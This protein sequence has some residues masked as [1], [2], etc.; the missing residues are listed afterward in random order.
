MSDSWPASPPPGDDA[1][2]SLAGQAFEVERA[3]KAL[4]AVDA[5]R[6]EAA[7]LRAELQ[8]VRASGTLT[9]RGPR[10]RPG[11]RSRS[12]V[13]AGAWRLAA[14]CAVI[15]GAAVVAWAAHLGRVGIL[16]TLGGTWLV[17]A[18]FEAVA[19]RSSQPRW[20]PPPPP[21]AVS[22]PVRAVVAP[23]APP[24]VLPESPEPAAEEVGWPSRL[25]P[26][27]A[28]PS[29]AESVEVV[30]EAAL[31]PEPEPEPVPEP[32][33]E[34]DLEP[35]PEPDFEPELEAEPLVLVPEIEPDGGPSA[36]AYAVLEEAA[37][38]RGAD[39]TRPRRWW[40]RFR[41]REQTKLLEAA[42]LEPLVAESEPTLEPEAEQVLIEPEVV[43]DAQPGRRW[44]IFGSREEPAAGDLPAPASIDEEPIAH[45][46][47][48]P[49]LNL[50]LPA[51]ALLEPEDAVEAEAVGTLT[52]LEDVAEPPDAEHAQTDRRWRFFGS[53]E[54]PADLQELES[55]VEEPEPDEPESIAHVENEAEPGSPAPAPL[56]SEYGWPSRP[57]QVELPGQ[58]ETEAEDELLLDAGEPEELEEAISEA[59]PVDEEAEAEAVGAFAEF[60]ETVEPADPERAP[61]RRWR[62]FGSREEPVDLLGSE[63]IEEPDPELIS[64]FQEHEPES[65]VDLVLPSPAPLESEYGWPSRP[66]PIEMPGQPEAEAEDELLVE[67]G[68]LEEFEG[69]SASEADSEEVEAETVGASAALEEA[70]EPADPEHA[71]PSRRWRLF[72]SREAPA[73]LN[74]AESILEEPEPE[75]IVHME[76]EV[77]PVLSAPA[78][79]ESEYDWP[80]RPGAIEL[81]LQPLAAEQAGAEATAAQARVEPPAPLEPEPEPQEPLYFI[82]LVEPDG[83]PCVGAFT[84]LAEVAV[85]RDESP[86]E[87][88]SAPRSR[89]RLRLRRR[90]VRF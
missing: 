58:P 49:E 11:L 5:F 78:P 81:P 15:V 41:R 28:T 60:E 73:G 72:G 43:P 46:V 10:R 59:E 14:E 8:A 77:E 31:E 36:G 89:R 69:A 3:L 44:R 74:E 68:E 62:F 30:S 6:A 65:E 13:P 83:G 86:A 1:S 52:P 37:E 55:I 79:L 84:L 90:R 38:L 61:G 47:P 17:V 51:P 32:E 7:A 27:E 19:S 70:A 63:S 25:E 80:S 22:P 57:G 42:Q 64:Q 87:P 35:E 18:V 71:H 26:V 45:L 34:H 85:R 33:P 50:V 9:G 76:A 75:P 23:P 16:L 54:T 56:E 88:F 20:V 39:A 24:P 2:D 53:R 21:A 66:G 82:S 12:A 48:E 67:P 29:A 40:S 4:E